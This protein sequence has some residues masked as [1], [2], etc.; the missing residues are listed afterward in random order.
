MD[1]KILTYIN[2]NWHNSKFFNT[3]FKCITFIGD[4]GYF[5]ILL[6]L[7]LLI[8]KKTRK[9]G[10]LSFIGLGATLLINNLILKNIFDRARPFETHPE[11]IDFLKSINLELPDSLSFPSGHAFS[12]F[13]CTIIIFLELKKYWAFLYV[14]ATL[15]AFSRI[16]LLVHYPTDVIA[17]AII[18]SLFGL[19]IFILGN[20]TFTKIKAY[21]IKKKSSTKQTEITVNTYTKDEN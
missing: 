1:Y 20:I 6:S 2:E 17:G 19:L 12:S 18:G 4:K 14:P 13:C 16:F 11:F 9:A 15:I 8:F 7:I 10:I 5:W 3:F 21:I